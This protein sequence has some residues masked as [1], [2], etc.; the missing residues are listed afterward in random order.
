MG[1]I[2]GS[3]LLPSPDISAL[4][5]MST[6]HTLPPARFDSRM[7]E[8]YERNRKVLLDD[9][10]PIL[11][12]CGGATD[13]LV[14]S[15]SC[16]LPLSRVAEEGPY[17]RTTFTSA[18]EGTWTGVGHRE[19]VWCHQVRWRVARAALELANAHHADEARVATTILDRWLSDGRAVPLDLGTQE[20]EAVLSS[21]R[22]FETL[23][24]DEH[25]FLKDPRGKQSYLLPIKA[26]GGA[27]AQGMRAAFVLYVSGGSVLGVGPHHVQD[28]GASVELCVPGAKSDG[29]A[30]L[31]CTSLEPTTLK[32]L[33]SP[34]LGRSFPVLEEGS[35]E[36]EGT[37]LFEGEVPHG[38]GGWIAVTVDAGPGSSGGWVVGGFDTTGAL[39]NEV[40]LSGQCMIRSTCGSGFTLCRAGIWQCKG[41]AYRG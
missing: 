38:L 6:P 21:A 7:E 26:K 24:E 30:D 3:S 14:P 39:R 2:V 10:T 35:D 36:S 40:P 12:L 19:M 33:P 9:L 27:E 1:G 25:I 20:T 11:S 29:R 8:L 17:R 41:T 31:S 28:L 4:I 34:L 13:M 22:A 32:L 15:E 5:T 16:I 23:P 37:V 18:L